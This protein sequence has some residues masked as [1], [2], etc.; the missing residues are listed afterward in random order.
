M[1]SAH[2]VLAS[3]AAN[4]ASPG[5]TTNAW[6]E[7]AV[8]PSVSGASRSLHP[9]AVA[10]GNL[11]VTISSTPMVSQPGPFSQG[12]TQ[13]AEKTDIQIKQDG[14]AIM[15]LQASAKLADVVKALNALG[16]TAQDLIAILQALKA[17]GSLKADLEII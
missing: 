15:Q 17:S 1:R 8:P 3:D 14:G 10:H 5:S 12:T 16:A 13:V 9:S 7:L 6:P 4:D 11:S 2:S